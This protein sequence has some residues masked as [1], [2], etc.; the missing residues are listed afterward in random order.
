[1]KKNAG[2]L[3]RG[4]RILLGVGLIAWA[5]GLDGPVWAW[6]GVVPLLT[7]LAGYCPL[8]SLV[9]LNTCPLKKI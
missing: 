9:G 1:M 8:Y 7:G 4:F 2:F 3:D 5:V 6:V